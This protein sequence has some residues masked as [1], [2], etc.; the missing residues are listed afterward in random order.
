LF[1]VGIGGLSN[2]RPEN[3][4]SIRATWLIMSVR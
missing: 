2:V 4:D 1:R 3:A